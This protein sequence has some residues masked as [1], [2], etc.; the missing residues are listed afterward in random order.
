[1][2]ARVPAKA[3]KQLPHK[4]GGQTTESE[5]LDTERPLEAQ[6]AAKSFSVDSLGREGPAAAGQLDART[7]SKC[8]TGLGSRLA[9]SHKNNIQWYK[10]ALDDKMEWGGLLAR[11]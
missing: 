2:T 9:P 11:W 7:G 10:N 5:M 4:P 3:Q 1:M 6:R 8:W